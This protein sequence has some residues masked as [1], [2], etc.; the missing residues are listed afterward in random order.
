MKNVVVEGAVPITIDGVHNAIK[1]ILGDDN[2]PISRLT[3]AVQQMLGVQTVPRHDEEQS[4]PL[5]VD[6]CPMYSWNGFDGK[7]YVPYP[8]WSWPQALSTSIIW[9]LWFFGNRRNGIEPIGPYKNIRLFTF[10]TLQG[11]TKSVL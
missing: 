6:D 7:F 1:S 11:K 2:G 5:N 3:E 10:Q 9:G 8:G 4:P